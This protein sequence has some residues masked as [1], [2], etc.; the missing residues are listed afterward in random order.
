[1]TDDL[2]KDI[3]SW[4]RSEDVN[5]TADYASRGRKHAGLSDDELKAKWVDAFR[6]LAGDFI[7]S[8]WWQIESDLLSEFTLRAVEAP[9]DLVK[10]DLQKLSDGLNAA[11]KSGAGDERA[12][13]ESLAR[14][15]AFQS[16]QTN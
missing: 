8:E 4:S 14:F 3:A 7:N 6:N 12:G 1:M 9:F 10:D 2:S 11:I 16:K 5:R 15:R 13:E